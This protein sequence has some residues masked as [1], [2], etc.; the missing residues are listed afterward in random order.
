MLNQNLK[1]NGIN[2]AFISNTLANFL[3]VDV[4]LTG[5]NLSLNYID[6]QSCRILLKALAFNRNLEQLIMKNYNF[7]KKSMRQK[8]P[9]KNNTKNKKINK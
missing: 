4:C 6:N 9:Y 5:L 8:F 1:K 2:P 7:E 3:A